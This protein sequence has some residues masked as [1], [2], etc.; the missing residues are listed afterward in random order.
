MSRLSE[1]FR[2]RSK[3]FIP[4]VTAGHPNLEMTEEIILEMVNAGSD[5]VEIGV[6]FSDPIA[7][8]PVIQRSSSQ[9]LE[10][11]YSISDYLGMVRRLRN[12]TE[13]AL[14][15]MGYMNP[16]LRFGLRRLDREASE[17]GLDGVL[18][19]DLTPEEYARMDRFQAL[20][21]VF[22]SAPTSSAARLDKVCSVASG[23][24]YLVARTGVTGR[25]TEIEHRTA[26]VLQ[27]LRR[28]TSLPIAVGF[29][30]DSRSAVQDVWR[31]ADGAVV[32]SAIVRFID[33]HR[34]RNDLPRRVGNFVKNLIP[35]R[36]ST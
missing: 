9:A 29:G 20:D 7:D 13:A 36:A 17:A 22:L 5:I 23:F 8:G 16:F 28:R 2:R 6:P 1:A 25:H 14:I 24:V 11:G 27:Q 18:I 26:Q 3:C 32:G 30:I 31:I 19:S 12:K 21:T 15:F 34:E 33:E 10:H 4:F 35:E